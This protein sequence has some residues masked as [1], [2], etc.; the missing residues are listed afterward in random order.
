VPLLPQFK[1]LGFIDRVR[2]IRRLPSVMS[3]TWRLIKDPRVSLIAKSLPVLAVLYVVLPLDIIPDWIPGLGQLDD[4]AVV[5]LAIRGLL[6]LSPSQ[7]VD[8]HAQ[9]IG[10]DTRQV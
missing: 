2:L 10:L 3:L 9:A 7:V 6:R 1:R 5:I 4:A 8:E